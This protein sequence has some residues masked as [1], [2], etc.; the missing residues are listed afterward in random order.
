M[1][2]IPTIFS[3]WT[4]KDLFWYILV[5]VEPNKL[6]SVPECSSTLVAVVCSLTTLPITEC[7]HLFFDAF[8]WVFCR[9]NCYIVV[10]SLGSSRLFP[11]HSNLYIE[12]E[13]RFISDKWEHPNLVACFCC[14]WRDLTWKKSS[15]TPWAV[16]YRL[17]IWLVNFQ[18]LVDLF[19]KN[20]L[21]ELYQT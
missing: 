18:R 2:V 16:E 9:G 20:L 5:K 19:W 11:H 17:P 6:P 8:V 12:F 10:L 15:S 7:C 13:F 21:T 3:I 1:Y 4:W 14:S